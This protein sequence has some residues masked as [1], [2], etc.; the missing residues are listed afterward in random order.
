MSF[1][2]MVFETYA[3]KPLIAVGLGRIISENFMLELSSY[4]YLPEPRFSSFLL[5]ERGFKLLPVLMI[6]QYK[7]HEEPSAT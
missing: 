3:F 4:R 2:P 7:T 1:E 6:A 5:Q